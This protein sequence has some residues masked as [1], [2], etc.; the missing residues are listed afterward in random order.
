MSI[1]ENAEFKEWWSGLTF[2]KKT[3]AS[4]AVFA[5]G[6]SVLYVLIRVTAGPEMAAEWTVN[7]LLMPFEMVKALLP[8]GLFLLLILGIPLVLI[9]SAAFGED[10]WQRMDRELNEK[11]NKIENRFK[12]LVS[13]SQSL[14]P[15]KKEKKLDSILSSIEPEDL[16]YSNVQD[17]LFVTVVR[18]G[19]EDRA[20]EI[21]AKNVKH[22]WG[23]GKLEKVSAFASEDFLKKSVDM[24]T[25]HK[26]VPELGTLR[27]LCELDTQ[28]TLTYLDNFTGPEA[29]PF[30]PAIG[31]SLCQQGNED[32]A[33]KARCLSTELLPADEALL[34]QIYEAIH[35][36]LDEDN[37]EYIYVDYIDT[38]TYLQRLY[39]FDVDITWGRNPLMTT[40]LSARCVRDG[41]PGISD[42]DLSDYMDKMLSQALASGWDS[43]IETFYRYLKPDFETGLQ[44]LLTEKLI[45]WS[46]GRQDASLSLISSMGSFPAYSAASIKLIERELVDLDSPNQLIKLYESVPSALREGV[47]L[48]HKAIVDRLLSD[49]STSSLALYSFAVN[50][51]CDADLLSNVEEIIEKHLMEGGAINVSVTGSLVADWHTPADITLSREIDEWESDYDTFTGEAVSRYGY[52]FTR[53]LGAADLG[54]DL[55]DLSARIAA[56]DGEQFLSIYREPEYEDDYTYSMTDSETDEY[57]SSDWSEEFYLRDGERVPDSEYDDADLEGVVGGMNHQ[58]EE[59]MEGSHMAFWGQPDAENP[60]QLVVTLVGDEGSSGETFAYSFKNKESLMNLLERHGG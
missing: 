32:I 1:P 23:Q 9:V 24:F 50:T 19:L 40:L 7:I 8:L 12:N 21:L 25:E 33:S 57:K 45:R 5:V 42:D 26:M 27:R 43:S 46:A 34:S 49:N 53:E 37:R 39:Q 51:L 3:M 35:P 16:N 22:N 52:D 29:L 15:E 31:R 44:N 14:S 59:F 2:A 28:W 58:F 10:R 60:V 6:L 30:K 56:V 38:E 36:E 20:L 54:P 18:L 47:N 17:E 13:T 55:Q 4:I 48:V 41:L 11:L